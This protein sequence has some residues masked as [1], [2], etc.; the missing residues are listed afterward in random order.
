MP[1]SGKV[2]TCA[3]E[4]YL[5]RPEQGY[6]DT[7]HFIRYSR[8]VKALGAT[9]I[10][11][12]GNALIGIDEHFPGVDIVVRDGDP[13]PRFDYWVNLMT[14][15]AV[16]ATEGDAIPVSAR[17]LRADPTLVEAWTPKMSQ[18]MGLKVGLV[19]AGESRHSGDT[20]RSIALTKFVPI[21]DMKN[22]SFH[23]LQREWPP[24]KRTCSRPRFN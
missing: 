21:L 18:A 11:R 15:P 8:F 1:R 6:G 3:T 24:P 16:F 9:V 7:F 12:S 22:V 17:Y 19:W 14:L 4:R 20:R 13:M 10:L 23:L 5:L 2:R